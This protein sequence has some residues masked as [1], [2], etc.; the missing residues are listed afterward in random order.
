MTARSGALGL[1]GQLRTDSVRP[2]RAG[3]SIVRLQQTFDGVP[4][5]GG[6]IVVDLDAAGRTRS[7]ISET[8]AGDVPATSP[9]VT[10]QTARRT[11]TALL[12]KYTG[13]SAADLDVAA[14]TLAI[15][16]PAIL[17]APAL[18]G[19]SGGRLVWQ[20]EVTSGAT[21]LGLRH[22]V[23]VDAV[24]AKLVLDLDLIND[25]L[26]RDVCDANSTA[27]QVPCTAPVRSDSATTSPIADVNNAYD[28]AGKTYDFYSTV[29]G[30]DSIDGAGMTIEVDRALLPAS[31]PRLP[32]R[33]R[34][35][36]RLADGLRRDLRQ[37]RRRGRATSSPTA[38]PSASTGSSTTSSPARSTSRSRTSS[39][40]SST[41]PTASATTRPAVKWKMGEDLPIGYIRNM[42]DPGDTSLPLSYRQPDT[43]D[44]SLWRANTVSEVNAFDAGGV[45]Y[46]S[47]VGNKFAYLITD[48][49][50]F[51]GYTITGL[52]IT[53]AANVIY[54]ASKR[55]TSAQRLPRVRRRAARVV[56]R[57][58][59][60]QAGARA[61]QQRLRAGRLGDQGHQDGRDAAD[62]ED[63]RRS[64]VLRG[65]RPG[66]ALL[67]HAHQCLV[68]QVV[69]RRHDGERLQA[70]ALRRP[71]L[72]LPRRRLALPRP[73]LQPRRQGHDAS[74]NL[75]G[76]DPDFS[77]GNANGG[78]TTDSA[79]AMS[80]GVAVPSGTTYL[81]FT[82]A[83]G[84]ET[85]SG[86]TAAAR[87][88]S[89]TS[90]AAWSSTRS[91]GARGRTPARSWRLGQQRLR[92]QQHPERP[93]RVR[94]S[95]AGYGNP[96]AGRPAFTWQS[97]GYVSSRAN[98]S[99]LA[100]KSV[101]FRFRIA[102]DKLG[103]D[104]GW[105]IDD[106]SIY[107]CTPL[108]STPS[109]VVFGA[110]RGE[111]PGQ[112]LHAALDEDLP[113]GGRGVRAAAVGVRRPGGGPGVAH[114]HAVSAAGGTACVWMTSTETGTG[115]STSATRVRHAAGR[116]PDA[117]GVERVEEVVVVER[118]RQ[119]AARREEEGED[120]H[121]QRAHAAP[122]WWCS[123][124]P[125]RRAARSASY[126]NG[127]RVG[128]INLKAKK[129]GAVRVDL[130]VSGLAGGKVVLKVL[131]AGT[132]AIDGI[133]VRP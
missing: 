93:Q 100:G 89:T 131:K 133:A 4:V 32:L 78:F 87:R 99:S 121:A 28:Y 51:K 82:H 17:G 59:R 126:V 108:L 66:D 105:F 39:A 106:V 42:K 114:H 113:P 14:P 11:M 111:L 122:T 107:S 41:R 115:Q 123:R 52:G 81:R 90:T 53:K 12:A 109:T 56:Q 84:F 119:D 19:V 79:I 97:Q 26:H 16:D 96:L 6:E 118:L 57:A 15:Y 21:D 5:I 77:G 117:V 40:S 30:R 71:A 132:V 8:L 36:E 2:T 63:A 38:S 72:G 130:G 103:G 20:S 31:E 49:D 74:A 94:R 80:S 43:T 92:L 23:L 45:H 83:F 125:R 33:Q 25:A 44:S 64:G 98:L 128:T 50:I 61:D 60:R 54:E 9:A 68:R 127:K 75:W 22:L 24:T 46:N 86:T 65:H 27:T 102:T 1:R 120:P 7:A 104:Y 69:G 67:R 58:H 48:G 62:G 91:T 47:G 3:G 70:L 18:P 55:L 95:P 34:L 124:R 116:R 10:Q 29:L 35:L 88:R 112:R 101:K 73:A 37:R 85:G 110:D 76:D 13:R 129:A